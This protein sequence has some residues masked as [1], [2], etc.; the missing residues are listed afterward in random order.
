M[1][2][3]NAQHLY[4]YTCVTYT[5]FHS[6]RKINAEPKDRKLFTPEIK[7]FLD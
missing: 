3:T 5:E 6:N 2:I 4:V 1:K 7:W